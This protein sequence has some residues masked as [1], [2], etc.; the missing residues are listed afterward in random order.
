MFV[1]YHFHS[2][3]FCHM[4]L[5]YSSV[6]AFLHFTGQIPFLPRKQQ[7]Q[8][9]VKNWVVGC[10]YGYV[11]G[12]RCRFA[13]G[14]ADATATYCLMLQWIQIGFTFL[15]PVTQVVPDKIQ[16]GR[17][18]GVC[19]YVHFCSVSFWC[20]LCL[21]KVLCY[22]SSGLIIDFKFENIFYKS[23]LK[24]H[25]CL[26]LYKVHCTQIQWVCLQLFA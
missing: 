23:G 25:R 8:C 22:N 7:H 20:C 16:E 1:V 10:W 12:S 17:K 11:S 2:D 6:Q 13:Y 9:T 21:L 15:V 19:V 18:T 4:S 26:C 14:P 5:L 3:N 24:Q